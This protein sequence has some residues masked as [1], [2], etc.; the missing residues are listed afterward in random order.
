MT[1]WVHPG[2]GWGSARW[3]DEIAAHAALPDDV[4][5]E[6][7]S[8]SRDC[9]AIASLPTAI[10]LPALDALGAMQDPGAR[11]TTLLAQRLD[12]SPYVVKHSSKEGF[13]EV[14][15]VGTRGAAARNLRRAV[16]IAALVPSCRDLLFVDCHPQ[17]PILKTPPPGIRRRSI[18]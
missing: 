13:V 17:R 7:L 1:L 15:R 8:L 6:A 16:C 4:R 18:R 5:A 9:D 14:G 3:R 11:F 10:R 2:T 12:S